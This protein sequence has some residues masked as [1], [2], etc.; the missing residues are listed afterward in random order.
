MAGQHQLE[1]AIAA[2]EALA[3]HRAR[4]GGGRPPS[5]P[6]AGSSRRSMPPA[7]RRRQV[8]VLFAD[9]SGFTAMSE[10]MD[11]ELVSGMMNDIWAR[12]DV[13][14]TEHGGRIDKHIGDAVMAVWGAE[15]TREDDPER[16]VRAGLAAPGASWRRSPLQAGMQVAM[17]VGISTGP[18]HLG[19]V[20]TTAESTVMGDTVNVASR[21]EHLAPIHG[22]LIS[23]ET[24][25]TVRGV[26]DVQPL[27]EV[28]VRGK[29]EH[30]PRVPGR[31]GQ[32]TR[33][34]TADAGR[35]GRG[36]PH[37]RTGRGAARPAGLV[38]RRS[39]TATER[40]SSRSSPTRARES[41]ACST[42]S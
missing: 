31:A 4:R 12:L 30:G 35:R 22:V 29:R 39:S 27:G 18:A 8:T 21:L 37:H 11:A 41:P 6:C 42:S 36:D 17:R 16:A 34:S 25:R 13:V 5:R 28:E 26:F 23:H 38:Q 2:Q 14:V 10:H 40:G 19:A 15:A 33:L 24:Y 7:P 1:Q 3:G 9:V 20:G 32:A